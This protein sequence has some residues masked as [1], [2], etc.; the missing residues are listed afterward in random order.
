MDQILGGILGGVPGGAG[1]L[2]PA[3]HPVQ[4][5]RD[6]SPPAAVQ[7]AETITLAEPRAGHLA[8]DDPLLIGAASSAKQRGTARLRASGILKALSGSGSAA[9]ELGVNALA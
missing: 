1:D 9:R 6:G 5:R 8:G 7:S 2:L 4:R 3:L